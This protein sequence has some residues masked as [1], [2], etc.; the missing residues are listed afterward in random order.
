[1]IGARESHCDEGESNSVNLC[2]V[3]VYQ[4]S[5]VAI[6]ILTSMPNVP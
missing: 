5:A 4:E 6:P 3:E 1:M 2:I